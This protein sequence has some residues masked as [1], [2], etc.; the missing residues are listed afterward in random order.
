M[1]KSFCLKSGFLQ[2]WKIV[3]FALSYYFLCWKNIV[4]QLMLLLQHLGVSFLM[5]WLSQKQER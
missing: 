4:T 1:L 2:V 3:S 5:I